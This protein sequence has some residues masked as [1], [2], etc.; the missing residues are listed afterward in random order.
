MVSSA[1]TVRWVIGSGALA[2]V[3]LSQAAGAQE[4]TE[5]QIV[6]ALMPPPKTRGLSLGAPTQA[7]VVNTDK[8]FVDSLRGRST[9]SLSLGDRAKLDS[10]AADKPA[11]D[12]VMEFDF[13]SDVLRGEALATADKL[14]RALS[15]REL[16][17]QTF[18]I[19][20]HTDAKG[21]EDPNQKLSER[22]ADA[23]K[24]YLVQTYRIPA[25]TLI[26]VGYGKS[27][28]K[29]AA[30]PFGRENRRVQAV[31]M[32]QVRTAER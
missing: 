28:L 23:V 11:I 30:D 10:V 6:R 8:A 18:M 16:K 24:R 19:A 1:R 2:L 3:A 14:G 9:R 26:G 15:S 20:G 31:N 25:D 5:Q 22:R 32:L 17:G 27:H 21:G 4:V 7:E 13:N 12:L 29:N